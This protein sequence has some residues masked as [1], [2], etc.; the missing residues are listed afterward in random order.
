VK[1]QNKKSGVIVVD[2]QAD[3]T[4]FKN[5][6]LAVEGTDEVDIEKVKAN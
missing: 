6:S 1:N 3:F 5:G 4:K 2:F